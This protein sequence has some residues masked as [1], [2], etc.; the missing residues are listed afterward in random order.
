MEA[1]SSVRQVGQK[2]VGFYS[3]EEKQIQ[4][5]AGL[6]IPPQAVG[7]LQAVPASLVLQLEVLIP[8]KNAFHNLFKWHFWILLAGASSGGLFGAPTGGLKGIEGD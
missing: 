5:E 3:L 6:R 7:R 4:L 2:P 1:A 8:L